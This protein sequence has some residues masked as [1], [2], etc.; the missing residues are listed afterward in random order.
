MPKIEQLLVSRVRGWVLDRFVWPRFWSLSLPNLVPSPAAAAKDEE[1][2]ARLASE[3]GGAGATM[4]VHADTNDLGPDG[5]VGEGEEDPEMRLSSGIEQRANGLMP[6]S[7]RERMVQEQVARQM[8]ARAAGALGG[9]GSLFENESLFGG[10]PGV[11]G[12]RVPGGA[13]GAGGAASRLARGPELSTGGGGAPGVEAWRNQAA[14]IVP[15][16]NASV[17]MRT[18]LAGSAVQPQVNSATSDVRQRNVAP[19]H[20]R[21]GSDYGYAQ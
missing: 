17:G 3:A 7:S 12:G 15:S 18:G 8:A 14:G 11:G 4:G 19:G 2:A 5:V 1:E 13:A 6:G 10:R 21:R 20:G 9:E 16:S